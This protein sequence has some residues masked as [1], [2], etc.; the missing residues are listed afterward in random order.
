VTW[1][2]RTPTAPFLAPLPDSTA[3]SARL[4]TRF[5]CTH[6]FA[7]RRPVMILWML[8]GTNPATPLAS[9]PD[10]PRSPALIVPRPALRASH[11][12]G[13]AEPASTG[14]DLGA[15][16]KDRAPDL[17]PMSTTQERSRAFTS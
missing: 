17:D 1:P 12:I 3:T 4:A 10:T 9:G 5:T 7:I 16:G 8:L 2:L 6:A 11:A 13:F 14:K 15:W